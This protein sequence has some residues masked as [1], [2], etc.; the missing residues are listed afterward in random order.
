MIAV[1]ERQLVIEKAKEPKA[2]IQRPKVGKWRGYDYIR[3]HSFLAAVREIIT[4]SED[5]DVTKIGIIGKPDTGKSTMA[6]AI[7]HAVHK[8]AVIPFAIRIFK[9][10]HLMNFKE[11]IKT[12]SVSGV[13]T[14][15]V[16]VF[17]DISFLGADANKRQV[18]MIKQAETTIR[19]LEGGKDVK[20]ILIYNY[21]YTKGLDKYLR[22]ADYYVF[23]SVGSEENENIL[24]IVGKKYLRLIEQF[25]RYVVSAK[26]RKYWMMPL[27]PKE[28]FVY[29]YRNPFIP[30]LFWNNE[31]LRFIISPQR[32]FMDKICGICES[33]IQSSDVVVGTHS[34]DEIVQR[35]EKNYGESNF[36]AAV[37]V[38][39]FVN[40]MTVYGKHVSHCIKYILKGLSSNHNVTLA[41]LA[42]HYNFEV[43]KTRL[44]LKP[45]D[46]LATPPIT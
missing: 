31:S 45:D 16:L 14:N 8:Y 39:L 17:D 21:H 10:E 42:A 15:Y 26:S 13:A 35:G 25:K 44:K 22:Q 36:K 4:W 20:I 23:T 27:G 34:L 3:S 6:E 2:E 24:S 30:A 28:P 29:K 12:L 33:G 37:K 19:H 32:Q 40:G 1:K 43:R 9:K 18:D 41:S 11:T 5:S 38:L 46:P 7:A